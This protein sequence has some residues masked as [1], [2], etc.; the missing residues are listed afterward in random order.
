MKS[1]FKKKV[2]TKQGRP[3]KIRKQGRRLLFI[4]F[5][6]GLASTIY[7]SHEESGGGERTHPAGVPFI[8]PYRR[9]WEGEISNAEGDKVTLTFPDLKS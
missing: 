9:W 3:N 8:L 4:F 2:K 5:F 1:F 7:P 6:I